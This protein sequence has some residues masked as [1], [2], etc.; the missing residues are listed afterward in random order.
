MT[1]STGKLIGFGV[2]FIPLVILGA[3]VWEET[4]ES[5]PRA[6]RAPSG[7]YRPDRNGP[8]EPAAL[9]IALARPGPGRIRLTYA[10][11]SGRKIT[12]VVPGRPGGVLRIVKAGVP[13]GPPRSLAFRAE[14]DALVELLPGGN[15]NQLYRTNAAGAIEVIYDAR[16]P[17]FPAG[18]WRGI[19][20]SGASSGSSSGTGGNKGDTNGG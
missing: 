13:A 10:N 18:V 8:S 12:V 14:R 5:G 1:S 15:Y 9:T 7:G 16:G 4:P 17:G 3:W 2:F 11:A 6:G 19:A 20:R